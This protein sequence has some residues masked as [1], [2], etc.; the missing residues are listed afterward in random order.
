MHRSCDGLGALR[1]TRWRAA[2]PLA[3]GPLWSQTNIT[4][5]RHPLH[6]ISSVL[7]S[8]E[9]WGEVLGDD[10]MAAALIDRVLHHCHLVDIRGNSYRMREHTALIQTLLQSDVSE[11]VVTARR[12]RKSRSA[13]H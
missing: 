9:R 7:E 2:R 1:N 10:V 12:F 8:R 11:P 3:H 13:A 4:Q 5:H 6:P